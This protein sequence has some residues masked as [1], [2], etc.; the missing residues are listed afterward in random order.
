[1][2]KNCF[3]FA[4]LQQSAILFTFIWI[5]IN[6]I[7]FTSRPTGS[8]AEYLISTAKKLENMQCDLPVSADERNKLQKN[9]LKIYS[10]KFKL[11]VSKLMKC[12][13]KSIT[14]T[15]RRL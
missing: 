6:K 14:W 5:N 2:I 4:F 10:K 3:I 12:K 15:C 1:M 8:A 13:R 9:E 7:F 11:T